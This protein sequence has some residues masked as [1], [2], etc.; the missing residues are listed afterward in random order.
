MREGELEE[1]SRYGICFAFLHEQIGLSC[2][3]L[4][5]AVNL[6]LQGQEWR[7]EP[8]TFQPLRL[9]SQRVNLLR[10]AIGL[11]E[12]MIGLIELEQGS[13]PD[14]TL[15]AHRD[16]LR[17][18]YKQVVGQWGSL[19]SLAKYLRIESASDFRLTSLLALEDADGN[20]AAIFEKRV[21]FPV[22]IV[23]GQLFTDGGELERAVAAFQF[24]MAESSRLDL[25]R[26]AELAGLPEL[27]A[28][29]FLIDA[30]LVLR[31][32]EDIA[33]VISDVG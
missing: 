19:R 20:P 14:A 17:N 3:G 6:R 28:E 32:P 18:R 12:V 2:K 21:H 24:V 1:V 5:R 11:H 7:L 22:S 26:V 33:E 23:A 13:H 9:P 10:D 4:S 29:A 16:R 8:G 27:E 15:A 31:V 30:G 25:R